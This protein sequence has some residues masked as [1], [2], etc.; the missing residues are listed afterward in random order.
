MR[1]GNER[2]A[3]EW[4]VVG[5]LVASV[6][7]EG[8]LAC[9]ASGVVATAQ[10]NGT[11]CGI[12]DRVLEQDAV[13]SDRLVTPPSNALDSAP[14]EA[15]SAGIGQHQVGDLGVAPRKVDMQPLP[16]SGPRP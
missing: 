13:H 12:V 3:V 6:R 16:A 15:L 14:G 9:G 11:R 2:V 10:C 5:L 8:L 7:V 4:V 1:E